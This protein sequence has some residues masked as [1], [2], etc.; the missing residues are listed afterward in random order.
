M[1]LVGHEK[2][3]LG[4]NVSAVLTH[5]L[6]QKLK[7]QGMF[8][9]PCK[10]GKVG[11]KRAM[12]D[13]G[14]SI[15]VMPLLVYNTLSADPLKETRVTV[16]LADRSIIYLEG[17]L[18]NVL[19]QVNELIFSADFYVID[20]KSD[21]TDNSPKILLGH[22][23]LGTENVKI[24]V[25][26]GLL[27]LECNGE[28]IKFNV[29]K[30]MRYP[31]DVQSLNFVDMVEPVINE[32]I[33]SN[34]VDKSCRGYVDPG[35]EYRELEPS[36]LVNSIFYKELFIPHKSKLLPSIWQAPQIELKELP[37]NLKYVSLGDNDTLLVIVSNKLNEKE[38]S[39]L[40]EVLR[41]HKEAI[42]WTIADMKGLSPSTCMHKIKVEEN[43]KPTREGKRRLNSP[44]KEVVK[45]EIQKLLGRMPFGLCNAPATFQRCMVN[46]FSDF[47]EKVSSDG[48]AVDQSK[49]DVIH[50][51]PYPT[52]VR[53]VQSFIG[54]A[55]FYRR[56]IKDFSKVAQPICNL[57]QK[58]QV[59]DFDPTSADAW[60][61][62]NE[63]L[64]SAPIVQPPN[65]EYPFELMCDASDISV[66]AVL[67]QK[68]GK[69]PHVIAYA[70]LTL[71]SAQRN[72]LTTEKELLAI[73]FA[74]EKFRSYLLGTNIIIFS[75]HATLRYLMIKKEAKPRLICWILLL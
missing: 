53:E 47:I 54:H 2:I 18:E 20:M 17:V 50:S 71:D 64:I 61:T 13:L 24:E 57:L 43:A 19:V 42:G 27:T 66:G 28:I 22:P 32:F 14:A 55:G 34:F 41:K 68:V 44:I 59:F 40:I 15:N 45:K 74:L 56:F 4:E 52:T 67:G 36:Y 23:F 38:E 62:L 63:K 1:R 73:V 25:R 70:S 7:D 48:I 46:I 8:T 9:I 21:R 49:T 26:S 60:D 30:S 39:D 16:Q 35:Y 72:Y 75:D 12:C 51:L 5:R 29:Y 58:D 37:K 33:E 31:E 69:E 11:V 65:W 6:P 3:K 10:I